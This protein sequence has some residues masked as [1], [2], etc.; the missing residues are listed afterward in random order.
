MNTVNYFKIFYI[1]KFIKT[2]HFFVL[3]CPF[4]F[5]RGFLKSCLFIGLCVLAGCMPKP[6]IKAPG[7]P[8]IGVRI[9][10]YGHSCFLIED[11][12]KRRFLIDPFNKRVGYKI[13][14]SS[15][16]VVLRTHDHFDHANL[17]RLS[18][19]TLVKSTG[20]HTA[21]GVE[22][23]G[24]LA[25]HDSS[26]GRVHGTTNIYIWEMGG[27]TL[28]HMGDIGQEALLPAQLGALKEVD[29]LFVPVGG[30]T[31]VDAEGAASLV[32]AIQ[33]R[34]VVPMHYGC[35]QLRFYA[36]DPVEKFLV[37]FE[38]VLELPD[39]E[40]QVRHASLPESLT[41]IVPKVPE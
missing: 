26:N 15:P 17:R 18:G 30:K 35:D 1:H 24:V 9:V 8:A 39:S 13:M 23:T 34:I 31:T 22:V 29:V 14:W 40:F 16:D 41:V 12:V 37:L 21:A 33:P 19:Y 10:W 28:A 2:D 27:V 20:V 36:F 3:P 7:D 38:N 4:M 5:I 25:Y 6:L 11:S 32:K